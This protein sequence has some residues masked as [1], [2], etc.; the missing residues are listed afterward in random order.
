MGGKV[1]ILI[2]TVGGAIGYFLGEF[3]IL[4]KVFA[5]I[6]V[7]DILTG[8][9]K[10]YYSGTYESKI[11]RQC[12]IKK[13]GYL[14]TLL[15]VVQLDLLMGDIG[16]LRSAVLFCFIANETTSIIENLGEV[17]I[18][19]PKAISNTIAVLKNKSEEV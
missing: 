13:S 1:N 2:A 9:F 10:G 12:I 19:I 8:M 3:D 11:F 6:V 15:L 16:A 18:P 17:G 4:L 7:I 5:T 14:L